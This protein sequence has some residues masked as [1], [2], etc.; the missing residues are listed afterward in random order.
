[1]NRDPSSRF[2]E[3][4]AAQA[5]LA[6]QVHEGHDEP[7]E[8]LGDDQRTTRRLPPPTARVKGSRSLPRGVLAD[9]RS[10]APP[11]KLTPPLRGP[12]GTAVSAGPQATAKR[13]A[14][15]WPYVATL[16]LGAAFL[17]WFGT[18]RPTREPQASTATVQSTSESPPPSVPSALPA[19]SSSPETAVAVTDSVDAGPLAVAPDAAPG[20]AGGGAATVAFALRDAPAGSGSADYDLAS[21]LRAVNRIYYGNCAV[22]SAGKLA[23]T[24]APSGRV[25]QVSV[26]RGDYD[27]ETTACVAARFGTAKTTPFQGGPQTVTAELVATH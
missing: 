22:P 17:A 10:S 11:E 2:P 27:E 24:F 14:R 1:V 25:K 16:A 15:T 13:R 8:V 26:L 20:R 18:E 3:G 23:I 4:L 5:F 19:A 7:A 6:T 9:A 21:T 12:S